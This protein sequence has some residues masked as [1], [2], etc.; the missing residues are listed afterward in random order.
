MATLCCESHRFESIQAV[1]F[2]KDGTLAR[3]ETYL[4]AVGMARWQLLC[5]K[6]SALAG[7]PGSH[8][9]APL[10]AAFG[11]CDGKVDPAGLLA[12]GSRQ[13]NE[14]AA[15]AYLAA[16][17]WDWIVALEVAKAAFDEAAR[18]SQPKAAKTPLVEGVRPLLA[19]LSRAGIH[20]GIVSADLQ[21]EVSAFI[22][23]N[24]LAEISWYCGASAST[25]P[26]THPA[27]LRF[28]CDAMG[29]EP[30]ATLVIGDSAADWQLAQ[31]GA[32]GFF[33]MTGG[34]SSVPEIGPD[35][36]AIAQFSQIECLP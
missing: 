19:R 3:V 9:G 13:E 27:F 14:V 2:D 20:A 26:K 35:V 5:D 4:A 29:V 12:V 15:A 21:A 32:A 11:L 23:Y 16:A 28:A 6:E 17:G 1:L 25:L 33:G 22:E 10:L 31:C 24:G 30:S 8:R 36:V 7:G 18:R 34:W